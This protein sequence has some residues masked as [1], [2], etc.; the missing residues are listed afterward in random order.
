VAPDFPLESGF[1]PSTCRTAG[2][3]PIEGDPEPLDLNVPIRPVERACDSSCHNCH[4]VDPA[5]IG[6]ICFDFGFGR[7]P[8]GRASASISYVTTSQRT[9]VRDLTHALQSFVDGPDRSL[10]AVNELI[11]LLGAVDALPWLDELTYMARYYTPE[12]ESVGVEV[13][14]AQAKLALDDWSKKKPWRP[15]VPDDA[16]GLRKRWLDPPGRDRA[17]AVVASLST[18]AIADLAFGTYDNRLDLRGFVYPGDKFDERRGGNLES[19][20]FSGATF[21]RVDF[22]DAAIRDCRFDGAVFRELHVWASSVVDTSFRGANL[23]HAMFWGRR[24][25]TLVRRVDFALANLGGGSAREC[26][27]FED[28][29]FTSARL[30][31]TEFACDLTRCRFAGHVEGLVLNGQD[32]DYRGGKVIPRPVHVRAVDFSAAE[33]ELVAFRWVDLTDLRLPLSPDLRVVENWPAVHERIRAATAGSSRE[34]TSFSVRFELGYEPRWAVPPRYAHL[35]ELNT[36]RS[37]DTVEGYDQFIQLLD[38]AEKGRPGTP[39]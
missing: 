7:L 26:A 32:T 9:A 8:L 17:S 38:A 21:P 5:P 2:A 16:K 19:V 6:T 24:A 36:L 13:L 3:C 34:Q 30:S 1:S 4:R 22:A 28:C 10:A 35:I 37:N 23:S 33:L 15:T 14:V 11:P 12:D 18:P 29:D 39:K 20:D 31:A 25:P 27:Q